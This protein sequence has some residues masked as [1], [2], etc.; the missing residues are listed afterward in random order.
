MGANFS[1]VIANAPLADFMAC[2]SRR[3]EL[4]RIGTP[5]RLGR[6]SFN[7]QDGDQCIAV[8]EHEGPTYVYDHFSADIS[9]EP[10]LLAALSGELRTTIIGGNVSTVIGYYSFV[11]AVDGELLRFHDNSYGS[12]DAPY[13]VGEPLPTERLDPLEDLDGVGLRRA[14]QHVGF[15]VDP[16]NSIELAPYEIRPR[17]PFDGPHKDDYAVF[18][19]DHHFISQFK[20]PAKIRRQDG[21]VELAPPESRLP[22]GEV[23]H[24]PR[25]QA[26]P[27]PPP[28]WTERMRSLLRR[29]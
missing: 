4:I 3:A 10:D 29:T 27:A 11:F 13:D 8:G 22:R 15:E 12:F 9:R 21:R 18:L 20:P 7:S 28:A 14:I 24:V 23:G 17:E 2:L 5:E 1:L 25:P 19:R 16:I 26:R 6:L